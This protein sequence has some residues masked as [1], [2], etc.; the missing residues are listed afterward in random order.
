MPTALDRQTKDLGAPDD[1]ARST[2]RQ[3]NAAVAEFIEGRDVLDIGSINHVFMNPN[4][5]RD[6]TF[7][8]L[9]GRA[10]RIVG[11]DIEA[12]EVRRAQAAG[13]PIVEGDAETYLSDAR[14][15]VVTGLDLIEHLSNPGAFLNCARRNLKPGG[16]LI[17]ATPN[18]FSLTELWKVFA[19]LTN[20]PP[21]H[22]QHVCYF[23]PRTLTELARRHGFTP[24]ATR[25]AN[26]INRNLPFRKRVLNRLNVAL[27]RLAPRFGQTLVMVF[28]R[29]GEPD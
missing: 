23:T 15:D 7:A 20:D 8:F 18:A 11:V 1:P 13:F 24:Q 27:T 4:R 12:E 19:G 3:L 22:R 28:A 25:Y 26:V 5:R 6:W 17:L 21:V 14:H 10:A 2:T 16:L 9:A 29:D